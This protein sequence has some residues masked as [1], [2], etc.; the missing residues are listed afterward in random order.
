M[1]SPKAALQC[2]DTIKN[3]HRV[4]SAKCVEASAT[5]SQYDR[6][7][8]RIRETMS[9]KNQLYEIEIVAEEGSKVKVHY[10]GYSEEYNEWKPKSEIQYIKPQ[11]NQV[12]QEFSPLT[13]LARAIKRKLLP[14]RSGD[15]EVRVQVPCD[16]A[17]FRALKEL[18]IPQA[19]AHARGGADSQQFTITDYKS[20]DEVFGK[21][22]HFRVTN[23]AGD[24]SYAMLQTICFHLSKGRPILEYEVEKKE[25]GTLEFTPAYIEQSHIIV[26]KFI[27]GDGNKHK[28]ADFL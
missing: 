19:R 8:P 12:E 3:R 7:Q 5:S 26:F 20:L 17:S 9:K 18:G 14:S 16:T 28:L 4:P 24:F 11:F 23:K 2:I 15:P 13:E 21:N 25:D 22:W 6:G 10:C 1:S 27:R